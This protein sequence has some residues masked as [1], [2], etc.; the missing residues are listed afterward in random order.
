MPRKPSY[1]TL[2]RR[3]LALE[4]SEAELRQTQAGLRK[5]NALFQKIFEGS[6][7]PVFITGKDAGFVQINRA[8]CEL[9]GYSR[10]ELLSMR[11]PDLHAPEDLGPYKAF[12]NRIISGEDILSEAS[13]LR[14]DGA[15]VPVEF[16]NT[17][18]TLDGRPCM[19]TTARD[20]TGRRQL[21]TELYKRS[22][23]IEASMDGIAMLNS[24]EQYIY[25]N[26]AHARTYGYSRPENLLGQT[27]RTLYDKKE[28]EQFDTVIMPEFRRKGKWRGETV[29]RKKDGTRFPQEV[30]L[31]T[32]KDGGLVC[33]VRDISDQKKAEREKL[34]AQTK[35]ARHEKYA[36]VGQVAGKMAHDFNNVL[37]AVMGNTELALLDCETPRLKEALEQILAQVLR[38]RNL[39][40][41]L[42]AFAKDQ[43]PRKERFPAAEK[44]DMV[45]NL[46]KQDMKEIAVTRAWGR[47]LPDLQADPGMVEHC[48]VNLIQNAVHAMSN[49]R[50][51][52]LSLKISEKGS[53]VLIEI[54]DNGCGIPASVIP[55]IFEPGFTLKGGR[56]TAGAYAAGIRGAGYGLANV[57]KYVEHHHGTLN[58]RS[59]AGR[60]TRVSIGFPAGPAGGS[61]AKNRDSGPRP[62]C[63]VLLVEDETA[64]SDVQYHLLTSSPCH[65]R[66]DT[67]ADGRTAMELI[68]RTPYDLVSLDCVLPGR[69]SGMDVY[70]HIRK[71]NSRLPV[72]FI[73]G[74]LEFLE[75]IKALKQKD[76]WIDHISK[77]CRNRHY[78]DRINALLA[79]SRPSEEI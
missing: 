7:D 28:L 8:A 27:W 67:A 60:G 73:S 66:V 57:R 6:K 14:K 9:T 50:A 38:G 62:G 33:V 13:I 12:F 42:V 44:L 30:S 1:E 31:T 53:Q 26:D 76:P 17:M 55:K 70:A 25:L 74:N 18:I 63:S 20:L 40:R 19:H 36:L 59:E 58:V 35:A 64:I 71:S 3:I 34:E 32:L 45:L 54:Q 4:T 47:N 77:P 78:I 2:K 61:P 5:S 52:R 68:D 29:G 51:P 16:N 49:T 56:D 21:A 48:L 22:E 41:N 72:L 37:G 39:T 43:V 10:D 69:I 24:Q 75:S 15:K 46:M 23:A 79:L 11:V 65:H